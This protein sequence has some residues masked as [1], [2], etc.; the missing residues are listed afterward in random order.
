MKWQRFSNP[1]DP[2]RETYSGTLGP[3]SRNPKGPAAFIAHQSGQRRI[4]GE[5]FNEVQAAAQAAWP[6]G[7]VLVYNGRGQ[8]VAER[9]NGSWSVLPSKV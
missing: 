2:S 1:F 8:L 9:Y 4:K 3:R 7:E 5:T 6:S